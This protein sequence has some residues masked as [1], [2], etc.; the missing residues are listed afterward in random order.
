[1]H[2]A[3]RTAAAVS[4]ERE[5]CQ[6]PMRL[7]TGGLLVRVQLGESTKSPQTQAFTW[8]CVP[9]ADEFRRVQSSSLKTAAIKEGGSMTKVAAG[10]TTSLDGYITGPNDG[11]G[12]GLGDGREPA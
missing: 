8:R 3:A 11:P 7:L 12:R 1:M 5:C 2:P 4:R 6:Y 10:I 9:H